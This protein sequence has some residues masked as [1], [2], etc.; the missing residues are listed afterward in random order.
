MGFDQQLQE[1]WKNLRNFNSPQVFVELMTLGPY[2]TFGEVAA[3]KGSRRGAS[4]ISNSFTELLVLTRYLL[5][6]HPSSMCVK[7]YSI[8]GHWKAIIAFHS[9]RVLRHCV[10]I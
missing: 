1:G 7:E 10:L 6:L 4:V 2:S 9:G 5:N 3:L 8:Q